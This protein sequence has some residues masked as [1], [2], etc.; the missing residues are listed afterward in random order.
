MASAVSDPSV[1]IHL[2]A[3]GR[4]ELLPGAFKEVFIP[5]AVLLMD[6]S[7]GRNVARQLGLRKR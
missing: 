4:M 1:L 5:G 2:G 3:I 7:D 6:E